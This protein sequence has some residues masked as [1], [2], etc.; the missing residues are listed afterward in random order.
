M[1]R[2][3]LA[4]LL[5]SAMAV[6]QDLT[7]SERGVVP[8]KTFSTDAGNP[9]TI[10]RILGDQ[11]P[12]IAFSADADSATVFARVDGTDADRVERLIA[13]IS[14]RANRA[15]LERKAREAAARRSMQNQQ[16]AEMAEMM[17]NVVVLKTYQLKHVPA[18]E[19]ARILKSLAFDGEANIAPFGSSLVIRGPESTFEQVSTLLKQIDV[20]QKETEALAAA[21]VGQMDLLKRNEPDLFAEFFQQMPD[22]SVE[23]AELALNKRLQALSLMLR[24]TPNA[25][26]AEMMKSDL[27]KIVQQ[28]FRMKIERERRELAQIQRRLLQISNRLEMQDRLSDR[29]VRQR[30]DELL[31][32][33]Q[34][35]MIEQERERASQRLKSSQERAEVQHDAALFQLDKLK[36]QQSRDAALKQKAE[37]E[38]QKERQVLEQ[39]KAEL[40]TL[41]ALQKRNAGKLDARIA[42]KQAVIE[43]AYNK[44]K[45]KLRPKESA[46]GSV[47][48]TDD[49]AASNQ[50]LP[51]SEVEPI[52]K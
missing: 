51:E 16:E 43:Q 28:Q 3:F 50:P 18:E 4:V 8:V 10:A 42:E 29:I 23:A 31:A 34:E 5:T 40:E 2:V 41:G 19:A 21:D 25:S 45:Q 46:E 36:L 13:E 52:Q 33:D 48:P 44:L 35:L 32:D 24:E 7:P 11:F 30:V 47:V 39:L 9:E 27:L 6:G 49:P 17:D 26:D 15:L 22:Q 12:G 20:P 14:E 37:T 38:L 1:I